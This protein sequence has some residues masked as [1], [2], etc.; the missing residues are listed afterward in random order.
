M[1]LQKQASTQRRKR[2]VNVKK[3]ISC[4]SHTVYAV[5]ILKHFKISFDPIDQIQDETRSD[6]PFISLF[7]SDSRVHYLIGHLKHNFLTIFQ[8]KFLK[9]RQTFVKDKG[10][11]C[12]VSHLH[13]SEI[14]Y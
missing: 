5:C 14:I 10:K 1:T 12:I 2:S 9:H 3:R 13:Y 11:K 8:R 6:K 7:P 4:N